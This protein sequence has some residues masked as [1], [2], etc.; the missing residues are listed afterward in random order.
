MYT[1]DS[2]CRLSAKHGMA[3]WRVPIAHG[4]ADALNVGAW[5]ESASFTDAVVHR[6]RRGTSCEAKGTLGIDRRWHEMEVRYR[7][8]EQRTPPT[9]SYPS[10]RSF[11]PGPD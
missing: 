8:Q 10:V 1:S 9:P 7:A 3:F 6:H 4:T 5:E 11:E 2:A